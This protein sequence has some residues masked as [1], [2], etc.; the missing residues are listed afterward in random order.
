MAGISLKT[1]LWRSMHCHPHTSA[2][3]NVQDLHK[4][5]VLNATTALN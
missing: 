1:V 4:A 5:D 3:V 2:V